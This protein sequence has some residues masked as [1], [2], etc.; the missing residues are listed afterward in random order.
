MEQIEFKLFEENFSAINQRLDRIENN[1]SH[2]NDRILLLETTP[3]KKKAKLIDDILDKIWR[4]LL[5]I[6]FSGFLLF[7]SQNIKINIDSQDIKT[8]YANDLYK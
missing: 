4:A 6:L 5:I 3:I 2:I 7:F 8:E 1:I